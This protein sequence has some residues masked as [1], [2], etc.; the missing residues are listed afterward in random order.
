[1]SKNSYI[2]A[3]AFPVLVLCGCSQPADV[4]TEGPT[5]VAEQ[6]GVS[7]TSVESVQPAENDG[8]QDVAPPQAE[9][10]HDE[11]GRVE[12]DNGPV[13]LTKIPLTAIDNY[14]RD[15]PRR[16]NYAFFAPDGEQLAL[17]NGAPIIASNRSGYFY[18]VPLGKWWEIRSE[19]NITIS[20]QNQGRRRRGGRGFA[21]P[22]NKPDPA[23]AKTFGGFIPS[24]YGIPIGVD[25]NG[26]LYSRESGG[27]TGLVQLGPT[28]KELFHLPI[29]AGFEI[30]YVTHS[31]DQSSLLIRAKNSS[32]S[33]SVIG[34]FNRRRM[35]FFE[36][37]RF[38]GRLDTGERR[39]MNRTATA[40]MPGTVSP[41]AALVVEGGVR[42]LQKDGQ[43]V[44]VAFP[45]QLKTPMDWSFVN[46]DRWFLIA[47][48]SSE[49]EKPSLWVCDV[50]NQKFV[51]EIDFDLTADEQKR[52][53]LNAKQHQKMIG[54]RTRCIHV[55]TTGKFFAIN[56]SLGPIFF[57]IVNDGNDGVRQ[58]A[59][60]STH[61][62]LELLRNASMWEWFP[63]GETFLAQGKSL[64]E[65]S[66]GE[67]ETVMIDAASLL[68]R[69]TSDRLSPSEATQPAEAPEAPSAAL[70]D[71]LQ[72]IYEYGRV[73]T[74]NGGRASILHSISPRG[75]YL[76]A[77]YLPVF[78]D[79]Q[80]TLHGL[81]QWQPGR[82]KLLGNFHPIFDLTTSK[83]ATVVQQ[84][85]KPVE[86]PFAPKLSN[87]LPVAFG[88]AYVPV[89]KSIKASA[90]IQ[91]IHF[92]AEE[93]LRIVAQPSKLNFPNAKPNY[94]HFK[95]NA[96]E[97]HRQI[98]LSKHRFSSQPTLNPNVGIN[99]LS[100][101]IEL[102][103]YDTGE[104]INETNFRKVRGVTAT[105]D[106]GG[107]SVSPDGSMIA[108][109]YTQGM[110]A[111]KP[112]DDNH[113]VTMQY[114]A[115]KRTRNQRYCVFVSNEWLVM[116]SPYQESF[117]LIDVRKGKELQ[118]VK[119]SIMPEQLYEQS[120]QVAGDG[121]YV[122]F[123]A[124]HDNRQALHCL[125]VDNQQGEFQGIWRAQLPGQGFESLSVLE[126]RAA[127]NA[128]VAVIAAV[129]SNDEGS[130]TQVFKVD[131]DR[132]TENNKLR[133]E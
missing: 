119:T 93:E 81:P 59:K 18:D 133:V 123:I 116:Y 92:D 34:V 127:A 74:N 125:K 102:F 130:R 9:T 132:L 113:K 57:E 17:F 36:L 95:M 79:Q 117:H 19:T 69:K 65:D 101:M 106:H 11:N 94:F 100:S 67:F 128:P 70:P 50:A 52:F 12:I 84:I 58:F 126:L 131:L 62:N 112:G 35:Q 4:A 90:T 43:K 109:M 75:N 49:K 44:T 111:F 31:G 39:G 29:P 55:T 21:E 7:L 104:L 53:S 23:K 122:C 15:L 41:I 51:T 115:E 40:I 71:H 76:A 88:T 64:S 107:A 32:S 91:Q 68:N 73:R 110:L 63:H 60:P 103:R 24:V 96:E 118:T 124:K 99:V 121:R 78:F 108:V 20:K 114:D 25:R 129:P 83:I 80:G 98:E 5:G 66:G 28:G 14:S 42:F 72:F 27:E 8:E 120:L 10:S 61:P 87:P 45:A 105:A 97:P 56:T 82:S 54:G 89:G 2:F 38:R 46:G 26:P 6:Q 22:I 16:A 3:Y 33:D 1:M 47:G 77:R 37:D 85:K 13:S 86:G 48:E 30:E